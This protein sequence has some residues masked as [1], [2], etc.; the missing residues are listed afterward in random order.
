MTATVDVE[1]QTGSSDH[2]AVLGL[3]AE[4]LATVG[5]LARTTGRAD[6]ATRT[7]RIKLLEKLSKAA[8]A[9]AAQ[10]AEIVVFA[11]L[12]GRPA[13]R[14]PDGRSPARRRHR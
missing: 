2:D 10:A 11:R 4:V 3:L 14:R 13:A 6:D 9:A 8:A 12:A 1:P 5:G 7:D